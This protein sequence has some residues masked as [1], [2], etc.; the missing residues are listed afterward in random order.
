MICADP[1]P[2][3]GEEVND[4]HESVDQKW[5]VA[6]MD[7]QVPYLY[8]ILTEAMKDPEHKIIV[9]FPVARMVQF[10]CRCASRK[11]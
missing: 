2:L 8:G 7:R 10:M 11:P 4:T 3:R 9:F 5:L 1:L 6:D